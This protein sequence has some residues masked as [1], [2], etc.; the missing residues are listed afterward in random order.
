MLEMEEV[1]RRMGLQQLGLHVF[2]HN[3]GAIALYESL[4]YSVASLN[5]LKP[6]DASRA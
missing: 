3:D 1:A 4:G 2:A 6:L 5:M